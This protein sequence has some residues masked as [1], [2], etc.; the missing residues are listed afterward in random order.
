MSDREHRESSTGTDASVG[1]P[2]PV[3]ET[4]S[5]KLA[6]SFI[7]SAALGLAFGAVLFMVADQA[8]FADPLLR[9]LHLPEGEH[10][11]AKQLVLV[12]ILL[13]VSLNALNELASQARRL[14]GNLVA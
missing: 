12:G 7:K 6:G 11:G 9:W 10:F 2:S 14:F 8:G 5:A 1:P 4:P 13:G 3:E